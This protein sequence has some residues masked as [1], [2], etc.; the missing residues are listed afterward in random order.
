MLVKE[1]KLVAVTRGIRLHQYLDDWQIKAQ[2][3]KEAQVNTLSGRPD[4]V[5]RVENKSGEFRTKTYSNVLARGP[6]IPS[7]L[8]PYKTHSKEMA[9]T[10]GFDPTSQIK[11]CFDCK[12]FDVAKDNLLP[13]TETI[14]AHLDWWQNPTNVMKGSDFHPKDHSIF[15]DASNEGWGTH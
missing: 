11:T 7:R 13:L 4:S 14:S 2:S 8:G 6:R 3:Q 15:T 10:L 1:V 12:M 9:Q 5:L